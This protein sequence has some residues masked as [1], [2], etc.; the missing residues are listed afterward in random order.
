MYKRSACVLMLLLLVTALTGCWKQHDVVAISPDGTVHFRTRVVVTN[1]TL[2]IK[3]VEQ[4]TSEFLADLR[5]AGWA[6]ERAWLSRSKPYRLVFTGTGQ[7]RQIADVEDFYTLTELAEDAY[8]LTINPVRVNGEPIIRTITF[9]D[10]ADDGVTIL[11]SQ[12]QKALG[13]YKIIDD[14]KTFKILL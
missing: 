3:E 14:A 1:D 2:S 5:A 8:R 13:T 6:V 4:A 9:R 10:H 12:G 11:Y 7:L